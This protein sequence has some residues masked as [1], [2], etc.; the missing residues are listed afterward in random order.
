MQE[1][2]IYRIIDANIN[3][4]MEGIRVC[5]EIARF[6]LDDKKLTSFAKN[7]RSLLKSAVLKI[8][9]KKVML[10]R[11][12]VKDVGNNIFS[13]EEKS[14]SSVRSIF[15]ANIKRS[16]E[17]VRS[18]EEFIKLIQPELSPK[19]KEIRFK[20]YTLEKELSLKL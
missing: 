2:K 11:E 4:A 5:E 7:L 14:R 18:L 20:L 9:K 1:E 8:D 19:F 6:I 13:K 3:R 15:K 10:S 17:A 12:S 16:E